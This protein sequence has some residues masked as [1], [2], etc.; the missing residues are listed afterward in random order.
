MIVV[1]VVVNF[2][3]LLNEKK[4]AHM[5]TRSMAWRCAREEGIRLG[6]NTSP[7]RKLGTLAHGASS[8]GVRWPDLMATASAADPSEFNCYVCACF[9]IHVYMCV[10]V[11]V[12]LC[13]FLCECLFV[14][15]V[16]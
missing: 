3:L 14:W 4:V 11:F 15:C 13:S 16:F 2:D 10:Y 6:G 1:A 9:F 8:P 7:C 12:C 5:I